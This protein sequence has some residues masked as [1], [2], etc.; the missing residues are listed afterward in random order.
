MESVDIKQALI[1]CAA[2]DCTG[3]PY[4]STGCAIKLIQDARDRGLLDKDGNI[5]NND[6]EAV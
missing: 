1:Q 6:E 5:I 2:G 3:C 4:R